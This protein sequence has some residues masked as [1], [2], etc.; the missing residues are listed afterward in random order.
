MTAVFP[1]PLPHSHPLFKK[2]FF[3]KNK[4]A[5]NW[6]KPVVCFCLLCTFTFIL[7][8]LYV[9]I[10][11]YYVSDIMQ[12]FDHPHIVKLIGICSETRPVWIV[13]ELAKHGEVGLILSGGWALPLFCLLKQQ[14]VFSWINFNV[15]ICFHVIEC[16]SV[17][18]LMFTALLGTQKTFKMLIK[19]QKCTL[20]WAVWILSA[21]CQRTKWST[22]TYI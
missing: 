2:F 9:N 1:L 20:P 4:Q 13:M 11:V 10:G 12:Q 15:W 5:S 14:N 19:F 3:Y 16:L 17:L 21:S 7:L 18:F 8:T 6:V 22:T